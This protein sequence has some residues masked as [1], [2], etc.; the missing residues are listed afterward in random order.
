M[1]PEMSITSFGKATTVVIIVTAFGFLSAFACGVPATPN[2]MAPWSTLALLIIGC[3]LWSASRESGGNLAPHRIGAI[4]VFAIGA[5]LS[6][7][8][9]AH[10]GS[11]AFDRLLFPNL[12]PRTGLLPGR[13]APLAGFRYCLLGVLL[14]L[15]RTRSRR[16]VLVREWTAVTILTICYFGFV[17]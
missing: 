11:T 7:E 16:L 14:F 15:M 13:P 3:T 4:L 12:L 2:L 10:M 9:L 8:H 5:I 1:P 6:G 17:A